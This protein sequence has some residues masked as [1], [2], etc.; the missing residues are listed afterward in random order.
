MAKNVSTALRPLMNAAAN[1][2]LSI[3]SNIQNAQ[4][5]YKFYLN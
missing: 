2:A 5:F 1:K 4:V 3:L